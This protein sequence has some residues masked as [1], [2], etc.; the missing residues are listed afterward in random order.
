MSVNIAFRE[1]S[2]ATND[3]AEPTETVQQ[4]VQRGAMIVGAFSIATTAV[5]GA[6]RHPEL[7]AIAGGEALVAVAAFAIAQYTKPEEDEGL[8]VLEF[9]E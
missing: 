3:E 9:E 6:L 7:F 4:G 8:E 2:L 1:S 5:A